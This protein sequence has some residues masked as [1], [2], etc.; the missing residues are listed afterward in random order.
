[1]VQRYTNPD[2]PAP[3]GGLDAE[4]ARML[5]TP[6]GLGRPLVVFSGWRALR[7]PGAVLAR[8]LRMLAG[9][10]PGRST[11]VAFTL[12]GRIES[13]VERAVAKVEAQWPSGVSDQTVEVDVVGISMG[14]LVARAA[15]RGGGGHKRLRIKRLFTLASPHR[16][17]RI[18][19]VLALDASARAMRPGSGLLEALDESLGEAQYELVCYARL[20]DGWVG[21]RNTAPPGREPIW[22]PGLWVMGHHTI[23]A[24]RM[25]ITDIARR[26]RGEEPLAIRASRPP[27]E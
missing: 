25:I 16:G 18:A 4:W 7:L 15:A 17:A 20:R 2:F 14:G 10:K 26:L 5:G 11:G 27:R 3:E 24:D 19:K 12:C 23:S 1:M 9:D 21:A 8:R 6:V 22:T 13:A